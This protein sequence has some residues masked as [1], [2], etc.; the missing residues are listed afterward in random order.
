MFPFLAP[1]AEVAATARAAAVQSYVATPSD[2]GQAALTG[3]DVRGSVDVRGG[4]SAATLDASAL[5][6]RAVELV[7]GSAAPDPNAFA[8]SLGAR[9]SHDLSPTSRA[10]I[11][12]SGYAA[13]RFG[14]RAEDALAA[15]D[16]F[17]VGRVEYAVGGGLG[18]ARSLSPRST[19]ALTAGYLQ[20]G[21]LVASSPEAVGPDAHAGRA[22]FVLARELAPRDRGLFELRG[23]FEH[24]T[25]AVIDARLDRAPLDVVAGTLLLGDEHAFDRRLTGTAS[26]GATVA[27]PPPGVA[28]S[29]VV[30]S[31]AARLAVVHRGRAS[32][33]SLTYTVD[34]AALGPRLGFGLVQAGLLEIAARP[35]AGARGRGFVLRGLGRG[36][37]GVAPV[38]ASPDARGTLRTLTLALGLHLDVPLVRGL[39]V[40]TGADLEVVR[41]VASA[42]DDPSS[43]PTASRI[44][45]SAGLAAVASTDPRRTLPL[46]PTEPAPDPTAPPAPEPPAP[47]PR[48]ETEAAPGDPTTPPANAP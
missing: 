1:M 32:R 47:E 36:S 38:A 48:L 42:P 44:L 14:V 5:Y 43:T 33:A 34:Y 8:A 29:P 24:F 23:T 13:S 31:P 45:L 28:A 19:I 15:R 10:W 3:G 25:H 4:R 20:S 46:D 30:A 11:E 12:G 7:P 41:A 35:V 22:G 26:L 17:L 39:V 9:L 18:Y 2:G 37:Y 16:P 21:G 40:E 27:T 6:A